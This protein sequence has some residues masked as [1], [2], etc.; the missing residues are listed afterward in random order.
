MKTHQHSYL[1]LCFSHDFFFF[2]S[3]LRFIDYY[4]LSEHT[5]K[6]LLPEMANEPQVRM[7]PYQ[8]SMF[9]NRKTTGNCL[10]NGESCNAT[11][12]HICHYISAERMYQLHAEVQHEQ[13]QMMKN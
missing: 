2:N 12:S 6:L 7:H 10:N 8:N 5:D 13:Q 3:L 9:Y 4:Y 11:E 1:V